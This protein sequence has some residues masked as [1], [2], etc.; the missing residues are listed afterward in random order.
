MDAL[1]WGSTGS[2]PLPATGSHSVTVTREVT[3][4][5]HGTR[6]S[7]Y[8]RLSG[9]PRQR[10]TPLNRRPERRRP[11]TPPRAPRSTTSK[12]ELRERQGGDFMGAADLLRVDAVRTGRTAHSPMATRETA[13]RRVHLIGVQVVGDAPPSRAPFDG[14]SAHA[15]SRVV[16]ERRL[17]PGRHREHAPRGTR[18]AVVATQAPD[19]GGIVR[20]ATPEGTRDIRGQT[21]AG[22]ARAGPPDPSRHRPSTAPLPADM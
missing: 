16:E 2:E 9:G 3:A 8:P 19:A 5:Q 17:S 15:R 11:G 7:G 10:H 12:E 22:R 13:C 20:H 18:A 1:G 14:S 21:E 6:H 4:D